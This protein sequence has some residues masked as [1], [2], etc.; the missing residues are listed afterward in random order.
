MITARLC[1]VHLTSRPLFSPTVPKIQPPSLP[2]YFLTSCFL[3]GWSS[4]FQIKRPRSNICGFEILPS[5]R[6]LISQVNLRFQAL[7]HLY[8]TKIPRRFVEDSQNV[9]EKRPWK[10]RERKGKERKGGE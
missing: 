6:G 5:I 8:S 1:I 2:H 4:A 10:G 7:T 9:R 3:G